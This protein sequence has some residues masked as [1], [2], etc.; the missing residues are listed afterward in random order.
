MKRKIIA[1]FVTGCFAAILP[2]TQAQTGG[3]PAAPSTPTTDYSK[4][5]KDDKEKISYALGMFYANPVKGFLSKYSNDVDIT[6][7]EKTMTDSINGAPMRITSQQ[8]SEILTAYSIQ[9]RF[10]LAAK[11]RQQAQDG[12][13]FLA[14]N[15]NAPGVI[16]LTNGLQYRILTTGTGPKPG[17]D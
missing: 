8:E 9:L 14:T 13:A 16:T 7:L 4:I 6:V 10:I 5:F 12:E 15:K 11:Q 2:R 1:I 3:M 17:A